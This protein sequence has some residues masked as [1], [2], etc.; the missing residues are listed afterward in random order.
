M[1]SFLIEEQCFDSSRKLKI[2]EK[3]GTIA[4]IT[5]FSILLG[6]FVSDYYYY[7]NS[8]SLEDRS[9]YYWTSSD[10]KDGGA[11]IVLTDGNKVWETVYNRDGGARPAL[12]YSSICSNCSNIIRG[13]DGILEV[14]YGEYPQK[15]ASKRLQFELERAYNCNQSSIRKTGKTYTIDS[16]R[17]SEYDKKFSAQ[18]IVEYL[19]NGKKYVRVK[20]KTCFRNFMLSNGEIYK[21]KDYVWVEVEPIKWLIDEE[22]NI[23]LSERLL[24][25]GVQFYH[26]INYKGNFETTDIKKFMDEYFLEDI[27]PSKIDIKTEEEIQQKKPKK[28]T[29]NKEKI[30]PE[31]KS[32]ITNI[33]INVEKML[34][35]ILD[36]KRNGKKIELRT[37]DKNDSVDKVYTL[38]K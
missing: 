15:V 6:G 32:N 9:G 38:K 20:A 36:S 19:Y 31:N 1:L 30:Q 27:I 3:R 11:F 2:L 7:N 25:A 10:D 18:F 33:N 8:N 24:F 29:T 34:E 16:R 17:Y 5:D 26:E 23:A 12:P 22:S 28:N 21:D 37:F 35:I 14:E 4:P 13:K